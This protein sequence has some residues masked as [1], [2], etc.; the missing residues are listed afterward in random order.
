[1]VSWDCTTTDQV[2]YDYIECR[3]VARPEARG[4]S[5]TAIPGS[6]TWSG[7]TSYGYS[8]DGGMTWF[9][10]PG[11]STPPQTCTWAGLGE[12]TCGGSGNEAPSGIGGPIPWGSCID[13][14]FSF[15]LEITAS[16]TATAT[17][18]LLVLGPV[19]T[20]AATETVSA[21]VSDLP[22]SERCAF[23]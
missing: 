3:G 12:N 4:Y 22:V 18:S 15:D 1:M 2:G 10:N 6:V 14:W 7:T 5:S 11:P 9:T 16:V 8:F 20:A 17:K 21:R 19:D 23:Q 13:T